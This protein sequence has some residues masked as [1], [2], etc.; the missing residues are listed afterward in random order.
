MQ[1]PGQGGNESC[2]PGQRWEFYEPP[3][4]QRF[5]A[6]MIDCKTNARRCPDIH[7]NDI[8][9]R[10]VHS[11]MASIDYT[12]GPAGVQIFRPAYEDGWFHQSATEADDVRG[13]AEL[14]LV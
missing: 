5:R 4:G 11:R 2:T 7:R 9:A 10:Y 6:V 3:P 12:L 8:Q 13:A 14:T 1:Q